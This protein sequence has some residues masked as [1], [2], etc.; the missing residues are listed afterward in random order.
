MSATNLNKNLL[1][2]INNKNPY[3]LLNFFMSL[4]PS[5]NPSLCQ[6]IACSILKP[7]CYTKIVK[8]GKHI[9]VPNRYYISVMYAILS[10]LHDLCVKYTSSSPINQSNKD[11]DEKTLEFIRSFTITVCEESA[12]TGIVCIKNP[13][14]ININTELLQF[15][16]QLKSGYPEFSKNSYD[17]IC[18]TNLHF[19]ANAILELINPNK[20]KKNAT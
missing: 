20:Y 11:N 5:E 8:N 10:V 13:E 4:N 15:I 1:E 9:V 3:D 12:I 2:I 16:N 18:N 17:K 6:E 7:A 19:I 14:M